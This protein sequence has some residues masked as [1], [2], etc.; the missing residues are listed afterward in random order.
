MHN[1]TDTANY[2]AEEIEKMGDGKLFK[3]LSTRNGK[4]LPLVAWKIVAEKNYD[5]FAIGMF[6]HIPGLVFIVCTARSLRSNGW[7]VPAY[8]MAPDAQNMK[9]LRVVVREDLSRMRANDL[10]RDLRATI[11]SLEKTPKAVLDHSAQEHKAKANKG[12][13]VK[14]KA[15]HVGKHAKKHLHEATGLFIHL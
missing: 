4:G 12:E 7:I 13:A 2:I 15:Q 9:L 3:I 11:A 10:L 14:Q 1:L 5:E 6:L 8:T